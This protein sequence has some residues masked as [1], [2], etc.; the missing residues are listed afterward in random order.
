MTMGPLIGALLVSEEQEIVVEDELVPASE[1][2][3]R[4]PSF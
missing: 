4:R 1:T 3:N 2:S